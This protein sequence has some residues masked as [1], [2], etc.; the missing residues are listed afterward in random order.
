MKTRLLIYHLFAISVM[1]CAGTKNALISSQTN[2][3][4]SYDTKPPELQCN[5]GRDELICSPTFG[6]GKSLPTVMG[7]NAETKANFLQRLLFGVNSTFST[8]KAAALLTSTSK[9][10]E[11]DNGG[12]IS[13]KASE[14][15][16]GGTRG[17]RSYDI[18][19]SVRE[20]HQLSG[21]DIMRPLFFGTRT[22]FGFQIA[23]DTTTY[24]PSQMKLGYNRKELAWAPVTYEEDSA[25]G[26][27][28]IGLPS[29]LA[30]LDAGMDDDTEKKQ[31]EGATDANQPGQQAGRRFRYAQIIATGTAAENLAQD[32]G[33]RKKILQNFK[34]VLDE[35]G[36]KLDT[37]LIDAE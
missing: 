14:D 10:N 29:T 17:P 4:L 9:A 32:E 13:I 16:S 36:A 25:A 33:I 23:W 27:I 12:T 3:G 15:G 8:G 2:L 24:Y 6:G 37:N 7:F 34:I 30:V 20:R 5:I 11:S 18:S 35:P 26:N 22:C 31:S 21:P 28:K 19:R 1:G